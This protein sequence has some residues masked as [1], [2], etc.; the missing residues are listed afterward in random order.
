[1]L[2]YAI[3]SDTMNGMNANIKN[4]SHVCLSSPDLTDSVSGRNKEN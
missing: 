2:L 4:V 1:M 3:I